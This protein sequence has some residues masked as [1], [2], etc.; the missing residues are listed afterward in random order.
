MTLLIGVIL[1]LGILSWRVGSNW[2]WEIPQKWQVKIGTWKDQFTIQTYSLNYDWYLGSENRELE[3]HLWHLKRAFPRL[4]KKIK[5]PI[6]VEVGV[7]PNSSPDQNRIYISC[8]QRR[9]PELS[10]YESPIREMKGQVCLGYSESGD[11]GKDSGAV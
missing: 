4:S 8:L 6:S 7:Y 2:E 11:E 5:A 10:I 1:I 3:K 9:F